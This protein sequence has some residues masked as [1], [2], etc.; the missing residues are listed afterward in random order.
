MPKILDK[1]TVRICAYHRQV[2]ASQQ[3]LLSVESELVIWVACSFTSLLG[4]TFDG[5][6]G[7]YN[8]SLIITHF[9]SV[10]LFVLEWVRA[11]RG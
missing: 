7:G 8:V 1:D 5:L 3:T 11:L 10:G 2:F 9:R 4:R 6:I